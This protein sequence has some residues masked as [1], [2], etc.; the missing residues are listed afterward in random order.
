M[1]LN[2]L[3]INNFKSFPNATFHLEGLT[4]LLG[5]NASGKSNIRDAFRFLHG[6]GRGYSLSEILGGK[7]IDGAPVWTGIRGGSREIAFGTD[8]RF[9]LTIKLGSQEKDPRFKEDYMY[10]I[11]VEASDK[12]RVNAEKLYHNGIMIFDSAP[13]HKHLEQT[14][15]EELQVF[16][17]R[18]EHYQTE[19]V[20]VFTTYKPVVSQFTE[21]MKE[22]I[23]IPI[24]RLDTNMFSSVTAVLD[25]LSGIRF[26]DLAPDS[27]RLPSIP[28]ETHL[29]E[30]GENLSSV[31]QGICKE[32]KMKMA[33]MGW[34]GQ[35]TSMDV[36]DF[37]FLQDETGKLLLQL[38]E[39]NRRKTSAY[40]AS[41]GM[42]RFLGILVA[43]LGA[44]SG[45]TFFLEDIDSG[46]HPKR[47]DLLMSLPQNRIEQTGLQVIATSHTSHL[48]RLLTNKLQQ[49]SVAYRVEGEPGTAIMRLSD[50]EGIDEA[51]Q[52]GD[53]ANLHESSW[54]EDALSFMASN[55]KQEI[56]T[57][58]HP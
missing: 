30:R 46:L 41:E 3:Y 6:I 39:R 10:R 9:G 13:A 38:V 25:C 57:G 16:I 49:A 37:A 18:I 32:T 4:L 42:L 29:G 56:N 55:L 54:F 24:D 33:L 27:M 44:G 20:E 36:V 19:H 15:R 48:V 43:V 23:P 45:Q 50:I 14:D 8:N 52:V 5:A 34:V 22:R 11:E 53:L 31:L 40:S 17:P 51:L 28:G 47:L 35:L 21:H 26:L 1:R 58:M 12:P 7:Y 2:T